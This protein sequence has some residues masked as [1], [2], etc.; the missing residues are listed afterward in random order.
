MDKALIRQRFAAARLTYDG[1]ARVQH[2]VAVQMM[3]LVRRHRPDDAQPGLIYEFGCGTGD[4]SRLLADLRPRRLV[5]NDLCPEMEESLAD[6][7][8]DPSTTFAPGDAEQT[9]IPAEADLVTSCST[10][11]WFTALPR[12]FA[13]CRHALAP[14]GLL[15]FTTFGSDNLREIRALTGHGLHYPDLPRLEAMLDDGFHLLHATQEVRQMHFAD[16]VDVLRHLK[17]TGVTGTERRIWT[18]TRLADFCRDYRDRFGT[19]RGVTLTYHPVYI[20]A[21]AR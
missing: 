12:F 9:D 7:L 14:G 8:A 3:E 19:D 21:Q 11:Q 20:V 15:A 5:L 4:Y 2:L 18:R 1:Q 6:L 17:Q 10:L 16:P 13:R